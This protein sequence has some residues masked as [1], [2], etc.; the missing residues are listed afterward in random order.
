MVVYKSEVELFK[1]FSIHIQQ[2]IHIIDDLSY[3]LNISFLKKAQA[4]FSQ[5]VNRHIHRGIVVHL[6]CSTSNRKDLQLVVKTAHHIL[7]SIM[8]DS[9][10]LCPFSICENASPQRAFGSHFLLQH[11]GSSWG[12]STLL[13]VLTSVVVLRVEKSAGRSLPQTDNPCRP[14]TET[15]SRN[16]SVTSPTL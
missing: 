15:Q 2:G 13:K 8:I 12:F 1:T 3:K 9:L 14:G 11:P 16:L 10:H 4:A 6:C 7:G 5:E